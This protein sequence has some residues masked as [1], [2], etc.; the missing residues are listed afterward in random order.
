MAIVTYLDQLRILASSIDGADDKTVLRAFIEAGVPT[1]TYYRAIYG[2]ELKA[3]TADPVAKVLHAWKNGG[4]PGHGRS[5]KAP[6]A[7]AAA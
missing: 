3:E 4:L 7:F 2:A 1:S 6:P 5:A